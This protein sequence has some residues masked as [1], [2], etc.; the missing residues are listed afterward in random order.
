MSRKLKYTKEQ[1]LWAVQE[2]LDGRSLLEIGNKLGMSKEAREKIHYWVRIYEIN[3]AH[4]F[5]P[6]PRNQSY[7]KELKMQVVQEYLSGEGT[8]L[9]LAIKYNISSS[10]SISDWVSKYSNSEELKDYTPQPEVYMAERR[11][12]TLEERKEAVQWYFN[13]GQDYGNTAAHFGYNYA[14]VRNW[15]LKYKKDG[16]EGLIDRRGRSKPIEKMSPE[17]QLRQ[18][19]K[20]LQKQLEIKEMELA[21]LK[22]ADEIE[23]RWLRELTKR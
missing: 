8:Q 16:D 21:L 15:V 23:R 10:G 6:R 17:E 22:K 12:T 14:Q 5:D 11:Q 18:K 3:G 7:S 13:N 1:K 9:E 2:Y 4:A 19:N 20:E